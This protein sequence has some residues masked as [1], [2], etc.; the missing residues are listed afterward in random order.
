MAFGLASQPD[1]QDS[2]P[3]TGQLTKFLIILILSLGSSACVWAQ[4][5]Q[6][7]KDESWT[8]TSQ[9][10]I[11]NTN[12]LRTIES[13][14][15]SGDRSVD[16]Q[17]VEVLGPDGRY[18]PSYAI[19]TE[20][21]R[22]NATSTRTVVRTYKWDAQGQKNLAQLTEEEARTSAS[23][24]AQVVR[25]TS[26]RDVNGN[27]QLVQREV[28][29]TK[30]TNSDAQE[31]KTTVYLADGNG[32]FTPSRQTQE[33]QK[34]TSDG[35]TEV[36]KTTLLP[37]ANGNWQ[38][39]EASKKTIKEDGQNRISEESIS[40][41]DLEGRLSEVSRTVGEEN[42]TA[43]GERSA[44]VKTYS[45]QVD[46]LAV[47][48]SLHLSQRATTVQQSVSDGRTT[49]QQVSQSNVGNPS[50]APQVNGKN[51]YTVKYAASGTQ[52]TKTI[53]VRAADG[54]FHVFSSETQKSDR[55]PES[56][57]PTEPQGSPK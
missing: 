15:K 49:E 55:V 41:P 25:T 22:V 47:D 23:G 52:Q 16:T 36:S 3:A 38:L 19:E 28:A 29:D 37:G 10:S 54:T 40:R 20:T 6:P 2:R 12:P 7:K 53:Q 31:T 43:A 14:S 27:F 33:Q 57:S 46:G 39:L 1:N 26:S 21:I 32:G 5:A 24:D 34:R 44:T 11:D 17:R 35:S 51:K 48:G 56:P 13:H 18:Q 9:T 30:K 50:D 8:A 45:I 4:D 42:E